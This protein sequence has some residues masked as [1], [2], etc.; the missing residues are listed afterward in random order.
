[1]A[2][3]APGYQFSDEAKQPLL[4]IRD[5]KAVPA[6]IALLKTERERRIQTA[7]MEA[8]AKIG[9]KAALD[10]LVRLSLDARYSYRRHAAQFIAQMPNR[11]EA[12]PE[13][14]TGLKREETRRAALEAL[15]F[16][17]LVELLSIGEFSDST[18]TSALIDSLYS[19]RTVRA[20]R[21]IKYRVAGTGP[22]H[23]YGG[24]ITKPPIV[25]TVPNQTAH[26]LLVHSTGQDFGYDQQAWRSWHQSWQRDRLQD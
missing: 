7:Y 20:G 18:L 12:I 1:M 17:K 4:G 2:S 6:I 8:L 26:D 3:Y 16:A 14:A 22:A 10:T 23:N 5:P 19:L 15:S 24:Y 11:R 21:T 13:Y 25:A 9:G